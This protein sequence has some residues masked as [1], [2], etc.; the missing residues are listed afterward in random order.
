MSSLA[1]ALKPAL[2]PALPMPRFAD[3]DGVRICIRPVQPDDRERFRQGFETLSDETRYCRC[4]NYRN[5]LTDTEL[6]M[7]CNVDDTP[8]DVLVALS[9]DSEGKECESI[10]G[11]RLIKSANAG[12]TAEMAF[13]VTDAWQRRRVGLLLLSSMVDIARAQEFTRL[14]CYLLQSNFKA[15]RLLTRVAEKTQSKL[16][17]DEEGGL[18][19]LDY[20]VAAE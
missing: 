15:R 3:M 4:F 17:I 2:E 7:L 19:Q 12:N 6:D 10:G 18:L 13:L 8:Q 14:R 1:S 11:V 5:S 16:V 20:S 9:L